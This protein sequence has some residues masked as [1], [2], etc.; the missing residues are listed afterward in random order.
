[1]SPPPMSRVPSFVVAPTGAADADDNGPGS[2][3]KPLATPAEAQRRVRAAVARGE[4]DVTVE[5]L[6]GVHR[7][8]AP[9]RLDAADSG[10]DGATVT[11]AAAPGARP[12]ISGAVPVTGWEPDESDPG[13]HKAQVGTG[14]DTR[15]LYVDGKLARRARLRLARTDITLTATGFTLDNP[16]LAHLAGLPDQRRIEF[17]AML[18]FTNRFSPVESI[19]GSTVV[20]RQ[21]GWD[22]NTYGYDTVQA[23]MRA[24]AYFL[25]NSRSFL[26]EAGEWYLDTTAGVLYYKPLPG[27]DMARARVELPR[28]ESLLQIGG[29]YDAPARNLRVEGLTF[30]G[31]SWLHPSSS[32]GY[33]N[34]QTG[35][36]ISGVQEH[37]PADAFD[38]C[39]LGGR[40]FEGSRNGWHQSPSA[41]QV[42]A[43]ED[44]A[45]AGSTFVNLGSM[46]LGIGN[47]ANAHATGVGLGARRVSVTGCTFTASAG[48][49]IMIGGVRPDAHHPADPRM[50]NSDIA[51]RDNR[52][53]ATALEYLDHAGVF[54]SYVTRL[55][56]EHNYVAD[57]PYTG[58]AV[59]YGWGA[60]DPGGNPEYVTRG[61]YDFQPVYETPTTLSDVRI[62]GNHVRDVVRTLAAA[63][64]IYFLSAMPRSVVEENY[65]EGSGHY[66]LYFDEAA[67][68]LSV[69]RNVFARTAGPWAHANNQNGNPTGD[70]TLVG[71]YVTN[72]DITGISDGSR[73]NVVR[74]NITVAEA[75][76]P[77]EAGRI[78][79]RAGPRGA[80]DPERPAVG[81]VLTAERKE[82]R[83]AR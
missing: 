16:A 26:D 38:S 24:P 22:N 59:G 77:L 60:N 5:L 31:T 82:G 3:D 18:A 28:L 63:S 48:G 51:L 62:V 30:S 68:H 43:A 55:T 1:M 45:I 44:V 40:G 71:N 70:L 11:W 42:S 64:S 27:Q 17:Q 78:V 76:L 47:D 81:A 73:G 41:V 53:H 83:R 67:R 25:L 52:V 29:T 7:L 13:V 33:A 23:P 14:F 9:L 15:Q 54:A 75:D 65:C 66:G 4:G 50:V 32:D 12:V 56:V 72:P 19:T 36:F 58:I 8:T 20:M 21:P 2:R 79:N 6:D 35:V 39:R 10:R 61:L 57:L 37:R 46:A 49:G 74:G 34:Q 69:S 80:P